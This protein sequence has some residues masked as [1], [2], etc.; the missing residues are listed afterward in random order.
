MLKDSNYGRA[1]ATSSRHGGTTASPQL[2][3]QAV[4][5]LLSVA[6]G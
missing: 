1:I 2:Q 6:N 4:N 3:A 5:N